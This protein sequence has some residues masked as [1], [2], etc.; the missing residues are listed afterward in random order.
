MHEHRR[1]DRHTFVA[2]QIGGEALK[3]FGA[4]EKLPSLNAIA[5]A[6]SVFRAEQAIRRGHVRRVILPI[7]RAAGLRYDLR[8]LQE[9]IRQLLIFT[10]VEDIEVEFDEELAPTRSTREPPARRRAASVCLFS[11][12][13][14]SYAGLLLTREAF[15]SVEAVFCAHADQPRIIHVANSLARRKFD[16]IHVRVNKVPVPSI[17]AHGYA[18]L[19]GFLYLLCGAA[20]VHELRASRLVVTECGPTM[21][22]P[23]FSPVDSITMTTHP[24]VVRTASQIMD[25]LLQRRVRISVPFAN[26]T[27]AEVVAICPDKDGLKMTHSCVSSRFGTHDGT[28]YG[29][30]IRRLATTASG[31]DDVRYN[32]N[33][34]A[35]TL[36]SSGNLLSLLAFCSDF[37]LRRNQMEEFE[38]GTIDSFG[39]RELFKRFSLDNFGA[40][41]RL[42]AENRRVQRP[43]RQF[44]ENLVG[45]IGVRPLRD[46]LSELRSPTAVPRF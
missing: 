27:K 25:L 30:V 22:Q 14:D 16:R 15:D 26:L 34:M 31:V 6:S 41:Y 21:Y 12:G 3:E 17:G 1:G 4:P 40:I 37:L 10:L 8:P 39:R 5:I 24:F 36:A 45:R 42:I 19:R 9:L 2:P 29:C 35:D 46:R 11:G 13:V 18:Q 23:R 28:C 44:Y 7:Y 20:W 33:P 38:V 43:V 32:K